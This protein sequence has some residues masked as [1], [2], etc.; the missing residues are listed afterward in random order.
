MT[1]GLLLS[2]KG[3]IAV[4]DFARPLQ[5]RLVSGRMPVRRAGGFT[6]FGVSGIW[7]VSIAALLCFFL[8]IGQ[9]NSLFIA[10]FL[11][12]IGFYYIA[13]PMSPG[14]FA[15]YKLL[16]AFPLLA[17]VSVLWSQFPSASLRAALEACLTI[18]SAIL[19]SSKQ[20]PRSLI[21]ALMMSLFIAIVAGLF[22]G[23]TEVIYMTGETASHGLFTSKNNFAMFN[24][25]LVLSGLSVLFTPQNR[26]LLRWTSLPAIAVGLAMLISARSLGAVIAIGAAVGTLGLV[27]LLERTPRKARG[28]AVALGLIFAVLA[29]LVIL[30]ILLQPGFIN[31]LL[32]NVGKSADLTGRTY[33]WRRGAELAS[34]RPIFGLGY[35]AFWV[36]DYVEAEGL[37]RYLRVPAGITFHN[38]YYE[39][40]VELGYAG[41]ALVFGLLVTTFGLAA[42][43]AVGRPNAISG[44]FIAL[45]VFFFARVY[46]EVDFVFPFNQGQLLLP[47]AYVFCWRGLQEI[48]MTRGV[49]GFAT[50]RPGFA[51]ARQA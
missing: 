11:G 49:R 48:K 6:V 10:A 3:Q 16:W 14:A 28:P 38:L 23:G 5:A 45:T 15:Q 47:I 31:S 30:T 22:V 32:G 41:V 2:N 34:E 51:V 33:L 21:S 37:W 19:L 50:P 17:L 46:V 43:W 26:P 36:K 12:F 25:L 1:G 13:Y 7:L 44:F 9:G 40:L 29:G 8:C 42:R 27:I 39:T 24:C 35:Q 18:A 20:S 4:S